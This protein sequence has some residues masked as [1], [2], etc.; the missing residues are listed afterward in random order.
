MSVDCGIEIIAK[1]GIFWVWEAHP[2]P[3][4]NPEE[5]LIEDESPDIEAQPKRA[6]LADATREILGYLDDRDRIIMA[7]TL[8]GIDQVAIAKIV[9]V[10]QPSISVRVPRLIEWVTLV[11]TH[12]PTLLGVP[13]PTRAK[14]R[15]MWEQVV[16]HHRGIS[17]YAREFGYHSSTVQ[18]WWYTMI[19]EVLDQPL[20]TP[21]RSIVELLRRGVWRWAHPRV[22]YLAPRKPHEA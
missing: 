2:S 15:H 4:G 18:K 19:V 13:P 9:G 10:T 17:G 20:T 8:R 5:A 6:K 16:Q 1:H 3:Y 22:L 12:K 21:E 7:L 11:L 14:Y